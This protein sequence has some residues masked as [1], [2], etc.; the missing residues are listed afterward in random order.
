MRCCD[1]TSIC[2]CNL[3]LGMQKF[4]GV[5][6]S[7][8]FESDLESPLRENNPSGKHYW[9]STK[10]EEPDCPYEQGTTT[11]WRGVPSYSSFI[12]FLPGLHPVPVKWYM[13]TSSCAAPLLTPIP[14]V[15]LAAA[16]GTTKEVVK[17]GRMV[18]QRRAAMSYVWKRMFKSMR[19]LKQKATVSH[20]GPVCAGPSISRLKIYRCIPYMHGKTGFFYLSQRPV[21]IFLQ[22]AA[23]WRDLKTSQ[24]RSM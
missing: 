4:D 13:V 20:I 22:F 3:G 23:S 15:Y 1:V 21:C 6:S 16:R 24:S 12:P 19:M 10:L 7:H 5:V 9:S 14:P 8:S 18:K 17:S 11:A 2:V